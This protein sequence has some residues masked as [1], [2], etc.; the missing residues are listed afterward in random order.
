MPKQ[1]PPN[2]SRGR[3]KY[4][5]GRPIR[6]DASGTAGRDLFFE[7][8]VEGTLNAAPV[9]PSDFRPIPPVGHQRGFHLSGSMI[10]GIVAA[11]VA[12]VAAVTYIVGMKGEIAVVNSVVQSLQK[13]QAD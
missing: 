8:T 6:P 3:P 5:E 2:W 10:S 1:R 12:L 4:P 9:K 7:R 11:G 13:S